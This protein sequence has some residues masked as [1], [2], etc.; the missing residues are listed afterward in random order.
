VP[1]TISDVRRKRR[2]LPRQSSHRASAG[3]GI[4]IRAQSSIT[5]ELA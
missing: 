3:T 1:E 2:L 5:I 4:F